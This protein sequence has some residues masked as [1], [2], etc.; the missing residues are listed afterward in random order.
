MVTLLSNDIKFLPK[1]HIKLQNN[2]PNDKYK[3]LK[4][5]SKKSS[6]HQTIFNTCSTTSM[7]YMY[8]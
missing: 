8:S 6:G 1:T 4:T 7:F 3:P 2:T 5:T